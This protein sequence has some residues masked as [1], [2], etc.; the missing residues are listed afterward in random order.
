MKEIVLKD[1]K[2]APGWKRMAKQQSLNMIKEL[3]KDVIE[4]TSD[5]KHLLMRMRA[6]GRTHTLYPRKQPEGVEVPQVDAQRLIAESPSFLPLSVFHSGI[7]WKIGGFLPG[8]PN[9]D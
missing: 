5:D 9:E 8:W 6:L 3:F 7:D 2:D 4:A 1:Y